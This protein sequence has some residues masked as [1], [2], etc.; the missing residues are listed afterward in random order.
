MEIKRICQSQWNDVKNIYM[1][2]FPKS[3]RKPFF[4]L[5][6]AVQ[7]GKSEIWVASQSDVVAGF[8]VLIPYYDMVLVEYL[9][10][11]NQI[12]SKGSGSKILGEICRQYD[13][14]RIL[15]LIEKIDDTANNLEQRIARKRFYL[16]NGFESSGVLMQG[17]SGDMEILCHGGSIS[18]DEFIAVQTYALGRILFGL[19]KTKVIAET[20]IKK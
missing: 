13:D 5:K 18:G 10:V 16:K 2:A 7:K 9:A 14:K 6:C 12:R 17:V 19:S 20:D 4:F 11:S 3:E 15:L 8:I 1:E